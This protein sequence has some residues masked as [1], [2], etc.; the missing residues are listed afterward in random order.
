MHMQ[1]AYAITGLVIGVAIQASTSL[2]D[3]LWLA[4]IKCM[5]STT[6]DAI[7][8]AH[9]YLDTL[10]ANMQAPTRVFAGAASAINIPTCQ[11]HKYKSLA[12]VQTQPDHVYCLPESE[13]VEANYCIA[14]LT[15]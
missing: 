14:S 1:A 13:A 10:S 3:V 12:E 8:H 7:R 9:R 6:Y 11:P 15:S 2:Y 5:K 4:S